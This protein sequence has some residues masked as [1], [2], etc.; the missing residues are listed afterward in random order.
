MIRRIKSF[1]REFKI[2]RAEL[3]ALYKF[4]KSKEGK[5]LEKIARSLTKEDW[6]NFAVQMSKKRLRMKKS[7]LEKTFE[8][9]G[10]LESRKKA[11]KRV[12][13]SDVMKAFRKK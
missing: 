2:A 5:K 10:L 7:N 13:K 12:W 8:E 4:E 1:V 9:L 6:D 11:R 3:K